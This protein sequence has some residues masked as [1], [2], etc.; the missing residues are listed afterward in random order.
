MV[1]IGSGDGAVLKVASEFK[2]RN[3]GFEINPF[4]VI[5]S[6]IRLRHFRNSKTILANFWHAFPLEKVSHFYVFGHSSRM[7]KIYQLAQ[8]QANFQQS[9]IILISYGF[10]IPNQSFQQ[11]IGAHFIY[12]ITPDLQKN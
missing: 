10:E 3:I 8:N 11:K 5:F 4:L 1:D 6:K 2:V 12:E 9:P 7:A